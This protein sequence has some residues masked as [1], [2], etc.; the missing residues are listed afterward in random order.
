MPGKTGFANKINLVLHILRHLAA[1]ERRRV[2]DGRGR[3]A[4]RQRLQ[5]RRRD[6]VL[7]SAHGHRP[8]LPGRNAR[9]CPRTLVVLRKRF[10]GM[11]CAGVCG[12]LDPACA[13]H[14]M[15]TG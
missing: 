10:L 11:F 13:L 1:G 5:R 6:M 3:L 8:G 15:L 9:S 12:T 7:R 14:R 4:G 2:G